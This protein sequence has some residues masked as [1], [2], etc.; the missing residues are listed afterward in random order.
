MTA[1]TTEAP[2]KRLLGTDSEPGR[3]RGGSLPAALR[4]RYDGDLVVPLVDGRPTVIGNFVSTLDGVVAFDR[5]GSNGGGEVSGFFE[6]DRFVMALLRGLADVVMVGA[7][8]VRADPRGRWVAQSV[9]PSSAAE[10]ASW[11]REMG[12]APN[13]TTVVVSRSGDV[14]LGHTGLA[15]PDIPVLLVTTESGRRR[16]QDRGAVPSNV[17][18]LDNG[19]NAVDPA[20]LIAELGRRGARVVLSEGGP[21]LIGE[22]IGASLLDELFLTVAPQLAGRSAPGDERLA[23][24]EGVSFAPDTA[25]WAELVDLR[26]AG[27]H[28]FTRYRFGES[29]Q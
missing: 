14:D 6:P 2:L 21:H 25:P 20:W 13:P 17:E 26:V 4:S 1:L 11:R 22:L 23:L 5:D 12:L 8:T 9:H 3:A 29:K 7:G 24:L 27:S 10:V 16:L 19:T 28:L 15:H 18:I